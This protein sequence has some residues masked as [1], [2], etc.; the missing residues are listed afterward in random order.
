MRTTKAERKTNAR[1]FYQSLQNSNRAVVVRE[2]IKSSNPNCNHVRFITARASV[3]KNS[4]EVYVIAEGAHLGSEECF[5]EFFSNIKP[6]Y[7]QKTYYE[8]GFKE[9]VNANYGIKITYDDG[10]TMIWEM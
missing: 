1:Q 6:I 8:D 9:W 3:L 5:Y 7:P 10:N 4:G 2:R